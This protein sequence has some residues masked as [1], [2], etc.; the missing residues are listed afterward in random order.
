MSWTCMVE[1]FFQFHQIPEEERVALA[2][3][4]LDDYQTQFEKLL[5]KVGYLLPDRQVSCFISGLK[6][7]IKANILAGRPTALYSAI[8]LAC[9]YEA[10]NFSQWRAGTLTDVKKTPIISKGN[11]Q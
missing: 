10:H 9:L 4:H 1:Q 5:T 2:S 6:D 8:G 11:N 7:N 3:F